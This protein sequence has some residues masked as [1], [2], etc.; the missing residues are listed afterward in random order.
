MTAKTTLAAIAAGLLLAGAALAA[1]AVAGGQRGQRGFRGQR[2][3]A[4]EVPE[5][6]SLVPY[7]GRFT[8]ARLRYDEGIAAEGFSFFRRRRGRGA[9][10]SHDYPRAERH[11]MKILDEVTG[12]DPYDGEQGGSI[13]ALGDPE[14]F[15]YPVAYMAEPGYW[16]MT[17]AEAD[18]VRQYLRKGG[19][20]V[21]DDFR[22]YD[23]NN[24]EAQVRRVLPEGRLVSIALEDPIFHSFFDIESL[25]FHQVLRPRHARVHGRLRGQRPVETVAPHRELQQRH[26][27]VLGVVGHRLRADRPVERGVQVRG[28][29]LRVRDHALT[30]DHDGR[31]TTKGTKDTKGMRAR[32]PPRL[33]RGGRAGLPIEET[34]GTADDRFRL[35]LFDR[36]TRSLPPAARPVPHAVGLLR[37]SRVTA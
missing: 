26:R 18:N 30:G 24:F 20:I 29:L 3:A 35:R 21:F 31:F 25:E 22:G 10:W 33:R 8:F 17:D 28:E 5:G 9:P 19:F 23:W 1:A 11:L 37:P 2:E 32:W 7:D 27:R 4:V 34:L 13:V 15:K 14:L 6:S 36:E 16:T 12:I